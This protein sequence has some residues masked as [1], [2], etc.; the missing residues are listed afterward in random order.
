MGSFS[1]SCHS[2]KKL[3]IIIAKT[4]CLTHTQGAVHAVSFRD[5][6]LPILPLYLLGL[7]LRGSL[8]QALI[9]LVL[10]WMIYSIHHPDSRKPSLPL[11]HLILSTDTR[12]R[13]G[14]HHSLSSPTDTIPLH[15]NLI[16][17]IIIHNNTIM[18]HLITIPSSSLR[19]RLHKK[20][21]PRLRHDQLRHLRIEH[22]RNPNPNPG[23][24]LLRHDSAP[25]QRLHNHIPLLHLQSC[26]LSISCL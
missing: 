26:Q 23:R 8:D 4:K 19:P 14:P 5:Q 9:L 17:P 6:M 21:D 15:I 11:H 12:P 10:P 1:D 13:L 20:L 18:R 25:L 2:E 16:A 24:R 3:R 22:R 7:S